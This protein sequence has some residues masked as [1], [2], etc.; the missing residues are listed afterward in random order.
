MREVGVTM[1]PFEYRMKWYSED[2]PT[3][4]RRAAELYSTHGN[5]ALP[6]SPRT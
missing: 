2:E 1:A 4:R 3:A 5:E 6:R